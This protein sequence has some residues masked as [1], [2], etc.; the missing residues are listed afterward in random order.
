MYILNKIAC[1]VHTVFTGPRS[2]CDS[3]FELQCYFFSK[4]RKWIKLEDSG[5][6][7]GIDRTA[8]LIYGR[9]Y[10]SWVQLF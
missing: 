6:Q 4:K 10:V 1:Y 7:K 8:G 5:F 2:S 3:V 9:P